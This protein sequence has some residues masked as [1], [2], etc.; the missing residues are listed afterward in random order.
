MSLIFT[1]PDPVTWT[2]FG[3][4]EV[5]A[6]TVTVCDTVTLPQ[7]FVFVNDIV[8]VPTVEKDVQSS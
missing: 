6:L 7:A 8:S 5:V 2:C 4:N 1:T 3:H